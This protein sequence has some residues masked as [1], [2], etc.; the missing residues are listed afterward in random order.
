[1]R[2]DARRDRN[3]SLRRKLVLAGLLVGLGDVVFWQWR[4]A[5][6]VQG[7][8]GLGLCAAL[9]IGR[10]A[11]RHDRRALLALALAALYAFAQLWDPS[12]LA[13]VLFWIAIGI[14]TLVPAVARFG[15][16]WAWFQRLGVHGFK[17]LAGP[18]IDL[19]I[20][21]K[22]RRQRSPA[23][24]G[25]RRALSL[26]ALPLAGALVFIL[27]FAEANPVLDALLAK[28]RLP[29]FDDRLTRRVMLWGLFAT[30]VWGV[31][32]PRPP[33]RLLG[34]ADPTGE[35][36]L[37]GFSPGSITLSLVLFN[38]LFA[39][40]NLMDLAYLSQA[41]ALPR[42]ITL[43]DYAHRGAYPLVVTALLAALFVLVTS[44]PGA[45][46]AASPAVR[47]LVA[48]W[49]VQNVV[50]VASAAWR[51]WDYVE[52]YSLTV[53]R[54][55]ALLWM[56]LVA[57]GLVLILVRMLR[58]KSLAWLIN[59][60][61]ASAGS[62]LSVVAFVDLGA[63]AANWNVRHA[64]EFG[65]SGAAL[66][67]CYLAQ[68]RGSALLAVVELEQRQL[69]GALGRELSGLRAAMQ[70]GLEHQDEDW[71]WSLLLDHRL[72][73]ARK[74]PP[75]QPAVPAPERIYCGNITD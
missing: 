9:P 57:T 68:L 50:L 14:A 25:L 43:A 70:R 18:L 58:G 72:A 41:V 39:A 40:Q 37:P 3:G 31:L 28:L 7:I 71:G 69:P 26:M 17:S 34:T 20:L 2:D 35:V 42:G 51:T 62:L 47:R 8:F 19:T 5:A 61:L 10:P 64:R 30:V 59:A 74:R 53:L 12:P 11:V 16:G 65:G 73:E 55:S 48:L 4:Q 52:A 46:V 22:V 45:P 36:G 75:K 56:G 1:M 15:D 33:R 21:G 49:I 27:L 24:W 67:L 13:F 38:A 54:I 60:N 32:R 66:D 6:G 23:Q 44:R 63:V 29:V